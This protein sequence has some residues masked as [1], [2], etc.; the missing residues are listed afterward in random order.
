MLTAE[1]IRTGLEAPFGP[2]FIKWRKGAF[3]KDLAYV[4]GP[5]VY[6]R[7]NECT[8]SW[9]FVQERSYFDEMVQSSGEVVKVMIVEGHLEIPELGKRAGT[10]VQVLKPG[11]GEDMYKGARTDAVKN[12]ASLFG[13][14][15]HLY[16]GHVDPQQAVNNDDSQIPP[17][18]DY[19][20]VPNYQPAQQSYQSQPQR[21]QQTQQQTQTSERVPGGA[22]VKQIGFINRLAG[23]KGVDDVTLSMLI[24][25]Q[26]GGPQSIARKAFVDTNG[27]VIEVLETALGLSSQG[28]SAIIGEL[29]QY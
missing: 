14:G 1:E 15:L 16:E 2:S 7:L 6:R 11:S 20:Q 5:T 3:N 25:Q 10:G 9:S 21:Q 26:T 17:Y 12:A 8:N 28:A 22:T 27:K 13:V 29:N 19:S 23:D 4:D 24:S 18:D